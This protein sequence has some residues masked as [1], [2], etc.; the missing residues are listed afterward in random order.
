MS[1]WG[2]KE[3]NLWVINL[4]GFIAFEVQL[5]VKS[6]LNERIMLE[7]RGLYSL[8]NISAPS[9]RGDQKQESMNRRFAG[10]LAKTQGWVVEGP[11]AMAFSIAYL[12]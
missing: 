9:K 5:F 7:S 11:S 12:I 6:N 10:C 1:E 2:G 8:H 3:E 4:S